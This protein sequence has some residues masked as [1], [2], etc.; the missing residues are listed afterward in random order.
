MAALRTKS[1]NTKVPEGEYAEFGAFAGRTAHPMRYVEVPKDVD[2]RAIRSMLGLA[3][4][5]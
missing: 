2:V 4:T 1:V 3:P 5:A